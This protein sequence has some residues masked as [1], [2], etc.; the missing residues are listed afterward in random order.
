[1]PHSI[2][3]HRR[4]LEAIIKLTQPTAAVI[5]SDVGDRD[6]P[7]VLGHLL[8][9][10]VI[11]IDDLNVPT[12]PRETDRRVIVDRD[13]AS[14]GFLAFTSGSTGVPKGARHRTDTLGV[15]TSAHFLHSILEDQAVISA[16]TFPMYNMGGICMILPVIMGGGTIV[17]MDSFSGP[18]LV[19]TIE[20]HGVNFAVLTPAMAE[21]L[22]LRGNIADHDLTGFE[23][24]LLCAAPISNRLCRQLAEELGAKVFIAYG[25]TEI[26]GALVSTRP[27]TPLSEI[28]PFVG[29]PQ[30]GYTLAILDDDNQP[31]P[32]GETGEI[33]VKTVYMLSEYIGDEEATASAVD[34]DGWMHTGDLGKLRPDG[35]VVIQGRKKE[36][37]I[38]GGFNVYP[39]EVEEVLAEH[40]QIDLAAVHAVPDP[41]LGE[42]GFAWIVPVDGQRVDV[43]ELRAFL[44][45]RLAHYKIPDTFR[46]TDEI[47]LTSVGKVNKPVLQQRAAETLRSAS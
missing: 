21:L 37:Y 19:D 41:V 3:A 42:K 45:E 47:P 5:A 35:G 39:R 18:K 25:L 13:P 43:D 4:E 36:M 44:V 40:L 11:W 12:W 26:P 24:V 17:I 29:Y 9:E 30:T 8:P 27:D 32:Q 2:P 34:S 14:N 38:R 22:F 1:M 33:C 15:G 46:V 20:R 23:R 6:L 10:G 28:G 16:S 7:D 31:V